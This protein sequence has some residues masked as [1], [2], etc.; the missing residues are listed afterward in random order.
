MIKYQGEVVGND[1]LFTW[2]KGYAA[3]WSRSRYAA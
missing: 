1:G 2:F 3:N